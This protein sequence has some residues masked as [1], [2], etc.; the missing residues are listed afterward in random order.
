[1]SKH[2][3]RSIFFRKY[4]SWFTSQIYILLILM[5]ERLSVKHAYQLGRFC[6]GVLFYLSSHRRKIVEENVRTLKAWATKRNFKNTVLDQEN[7]V[8]TKEIYQANAGNFFYSFSLMK[9]PM[10]TIR[11]YL[12]IK[13]VD[14]LKK[15]HEN[16]K[17]TILL[18]SH[19]GPWELTVMVPKLMPSIFEMNKFIVMYRPLNNY[20]LNQW[21]L[22]KR[23]HYGAELLSRDDGFFKIIR[24]LKNGAVV[25]LA[26]DIRMHQ[27]QKIELFDRQAS[28]SKI[29]YVLHKA[30]KAPVLAISLV[31]SGDLSWEIQLKEI[32]PPEN[33]VCSEMSLL[34]ASNEH[35][36]QMIFNNPGDYFFF[37]DRYK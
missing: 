21:Y 8:I 26:F 18:F 6:G 7:R 10:T 33:G 13:N 1:M 37:Q 29:P 22:K 25:N 32:V 14:L 12:E 9:K 28:T 34:K 3:K 11:K 5:V 20:Y 31:R 17:G 2:K 27:G 15:A 19:T 23:G 36:E 16:N 35:L 24:H 30:G 4:L